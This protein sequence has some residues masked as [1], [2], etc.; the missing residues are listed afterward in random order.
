VKFSLPSRRQVLTGIISIL[1][2]L[3]LSAVGSGVWQEIFGPVFHTGGRWILD[4]ASLGVSSYK[5]GVYR[6]IAADNPSL[7]ALNVYL[8]IIIINE[9]IWIGIFSFLLY[10][11]SNLRRTSEQ[12]LIRLSG[13]PPT[14]PPE[15]AVE[16]L[17]G[18]IGGQLKSLR[19]IRVVT[20]VVALFMIFL[21][22]NDL[23][24]QVKL[25]YINSAD[26]HYHQVARLASP[27]LD[28][29]ELAQIESDF[30][31]LNSREDYVKVLS[32]LESACN[33]HG[34]IVPQFDAW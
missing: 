25:S 22:A 16:N 23:A 12:L 31:Q 6:Q 2:A 19:R 24:R 9:T 20:W 13:S 3:T 33:A 18:E 1:G 7:V 26:T 8:I 34:R 4:L 5:N 32:S 14:P 29:R 10:W 30:A 28:A 27:Y 21:V 11:N 15:N 17:R